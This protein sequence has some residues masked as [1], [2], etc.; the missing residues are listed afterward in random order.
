MYIATGGRLLLYED[1]SNSF[2]VLSSYSAAS[3][4][5]SSSF[6]VFHDA[7]SYLRL[8]V[9]AAAAASSGSSLDGAWK[10]R[11]ARSVDT[12]PRGLSF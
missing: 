10:I 3:A 1:C 7:R 8:A 12:A 9:A 5:S 4:S 2:G 11:K 6:F